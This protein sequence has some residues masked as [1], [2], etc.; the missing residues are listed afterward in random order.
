VFV[1]VLG[2]RQSSLGRAGATSEMLWAGCQRKEHSRQRE[3]PVQKPWGI[4]GL[5][6]TVLPK[7]Q[8]LSCLHS[9]GPH[10]GTMSVH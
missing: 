2:V 7:H 4:V 8:S 5:S 6:G 3:Q 9:H 1:F 10:Q